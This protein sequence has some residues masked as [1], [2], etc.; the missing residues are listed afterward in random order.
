MKSLVIYLSIDFLCFFLL[1]CNAKVFSVSPT[2]LCE[3][4]VKLGVTYCMYELPSTMAV[5]RMVI[6]PRTL[7]RYRYVVLNLEWPSLLK[8]FSYLHRYDANGYSV[9]LLE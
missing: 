3:G 1:G 8:K 4:I 9:T 6:I 2:G 7:R 5:T